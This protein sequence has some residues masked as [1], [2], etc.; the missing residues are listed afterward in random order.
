MVDVDV[1]LRGARQDAISLPGLG[2]PFLEGVNP[3]AG[4]SFELWLENERRHIAGATEGVLLDEA[5][6]AALAHGDVPA[7]LDFGA[8]TRGAQPAR[9]QRPGSLRALPGHR[10][11]RRAGATPGR[12][13]HPVVSPRSA[14]TRAQ[15]FGKPRNPA[16]HRTRPGRGRAAVLAQLEAGEAACAAGAVSAGLSILQQAVVDAGA[17]TTPGLSARALVILGSALVHAAVWSDE[18]GAAV[19]H[20]AIEAAEAGGDAQVAGDRS[21]GARLRGAPAWPI[22]PSR[23]LALCSGKARGSRQ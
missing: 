13:V 11:S 2:R 22:R 15:P 1:L 7:A 6:L 17:D 8:T 4:V 5:A 10:R 12:V 9:R 16:H 14:W 18:E 3:A 23:G 19:L 21:P 20:Q